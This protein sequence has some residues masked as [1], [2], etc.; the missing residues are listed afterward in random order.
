MDTTSITSNIGTF[1][2]NNK[3]VTE[4]VKDC[5]CERYDR[6]LE[7]NTP[8]YELIV[9]AP[10]S[11][12]NPDDEPGNI[13]LSPLFDESQQ[14]AD[15][16]KHVQ[17]KWMK[18]DIWGEYC[19]KFK[20]PNINYF[21]MPGEYVEIVKIHERFH[22]IHHLTLDSS[23][24]TWIN[25]AKTHSF[26]LELLAQLFTY[27]H[28]ENNCP[29]S[30]MDTFLTLS[31]KQPFIYQTW[32]AFK[33]F[34]WEDIF[35][36]YWEIRNRIITN[37]PLGMLNQINKSTIMSDFIANLRKFNRK[38]R[39]F[40]LLH[41]LG[42][43]SISDSFRYQLSD[44]LDLEVPKENYAAMDYHIDWIYGAIR[45][46]EGVKMDK[47][48]QRNLL[49]VSGTQEDIDLIVAFE[50]VKQKGTYH[51]IMIEAKGDTSWSNHQVKSKAARLK[52]IFGSN[53]ENYPNVKP[54]F[55][56]MS[57]KATKGLNVDVPDFMK[58]DE[59]YLHL[60]F[61]KSFL[62]I[63]RCDEE[64]YHASTGSHWKFL[65]KK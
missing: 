17:Y 5:S 38:E 4:I 7:K 43:F 28:I 37:R 22:A 14:L 32:Q 29:D 6:V 16:L 40:L 26:Y 36:L 58:F 13:D 1:E 10:C 12:L 59:N 65:E 30:V 50:D 2:I 18:M 44:L 57:P 39:Y 53:G 23:G 11:A 34:D 56:Y 21:Q 42:D 63:T 41:A 48:Y 24:K 19:P 54:H 61:P 45:Y 55:I 35:N 15:T 64:G 3:T 31:E 20:K 9:Y 49:D 60:N 52:Y 62:R 47:A 25:F 46:Y 27:K 51:L 8:E 33:H